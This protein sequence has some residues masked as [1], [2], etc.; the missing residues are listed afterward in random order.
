M[1][2]T[3]QQ[4]PKVPVDKQYRIP[5]PVPAVEDVDQL[6]RSNRGENS[7]IDLQTG[8][9]SDD[10]KYH[11][12]T[13]SNRGE[14]Y[15]PKSKR[16]HRKPPSRRRRRKR[17]DVFSAQDIESDEQSSPEK[18]KKEETGRKVRFSEET[19]VRQFFP[20]EIGTILY[21]QGLWENPA[22]LSCDKPAVPLKAGKESSSSTSTQY[23]SGLDYSKE[24]VI[25]VQPAQQQSTPIKTDQLPPHISSEIAK[26]DWSSMEWD[27]DINGF[28]LFVT[29][30]ANL[31]E[32][33]NMLEI[34]SD[35]LATADP[36]EWTLV[37]TSFLQ[38]LI[39]KDQLYG[40]IATNSN[41]ESPERAS[42]MQDVRVMFRRASRQLEDLVASS[43]QGSPEK[44]SGLISEEILTVSS[45]SN[46]SEEK[47]PET[48]SEENLALI[49]ELSDRP[50][51]SVLEEEC[52]IEHIITEPRS[53]RARKPPSYLKDYDCNV[54][55][56][57]A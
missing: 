45:S 14:V 2:P 23:S 54:S 10:K 4:G 24:T 18:N 27:E 11:E 7:E 29:P 21:D 42:R 3:I 56:Q 32:E 41:S 35:N 20:I 33:T 5:E 1:Q 15:Y 6:H 22:D 16:I 51:P 30:I 13:D 40:S 28:S 19:P 37:K 25:A 48:I 46:G 9:A 44:L 36:N 38:D 17:S 26:E 34:T 8:Y 49:L 43:S 31:Q 12:M 53:T 52:V 47:S 39:D 55:D 50:T 57:S